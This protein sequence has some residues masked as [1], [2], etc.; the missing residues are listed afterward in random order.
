MSNPLYMNRLISEDGR[1]TTLV[2]Q[3]DTFSSKGDSMASLADFDEDEESAAG[4]DVID[5]LEG[6]Q[7]GWTGRCRILRNFGCNH[8]T[9][10]RQS[11]L[12]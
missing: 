8:H 3:A 12:F 7:T 9:G 4:A 6:F 5:A 11:T 2:I 10:Y 1:L